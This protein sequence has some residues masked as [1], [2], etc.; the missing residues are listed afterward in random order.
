[1]A[2][3]VVSRLP[4]AQTSFENKYGP[5]G[6]VGPPGAMG[7]LPP[8]VYNALRDIDARRMM[9]GQSP[10]SETQT[11]LGAQA[12]ITGQAQTEEKEGN[13]LS[14]TISDANLILRS[15]P[16]LPAAMVDE[17][18]QLPEAGDYLARAQRQGG[19]PLGNLFMA[20]GFRLLPGAFVAGNV[21]GG[22]N[23][24][25][26]ETG[27]IG[28]LAEHPLFTGLDVLPYASGAAART[29][30]GRVA[31]LHAAETGARFRPIKTLATRK[32]DDAGE[33]VPNKFSERVLSP[34]GGRLKVTRPGQFLSEAFGE[35]GRGPARTQAKQTD[36]AHR[37]MSGQMDF[38]DD[39]GLFR[40]I[41]S[42]GKKL[43]DEGV[44]F[45]EFTTNIQRKSPTDFTDTELTRTMEY[46][47]LTDRL[48]KLG[49]DEG[50]LRRVIIGDSPEIYDIKTAKH[51]DRL[52]M[53]TRVAE[54]MVAAREAVFHPENL[55]ANTILD[56]LE[57]F[58]LDA[59]GRSINETRAILR[60]K[61]VALNNTQYDVSDLLS[62]VGNM[63]YGSI[64]FIQ[65]RLAQLF[66]NPAARIVGDTR[67]SVDELVRQ[68]TPMQRS[69]Q[70]VDRVITASKRGD[71][72]ETAKWIGELRDKGYMADIDPALVTRAH[73]E[74]RQWAANARFND[75]TRQFT[76]G[77][78]NR[79]KQREGEFIA[80]NPSARFHTVLEDE[81]QK[82]M[83][84]AVTGKTEG[85]SPK[86][87]EEAARLNREV[88]S[89]SPDT[90]AYL[91]Y[92]RNRSY[93]MVADLPP[94]EFVAL[95]NAVKKTWLQMREAGLDP[96]W[97]H[98]VDEGAARALRYPKILE[99]VLTPSQVKQRVFDSKPYVNDAQ[100]ALTH[101]AYEWLNRR[102]S[103]Q[104]IDDIAGMYG[105]DELSLRERFYPMAEKKAA[106]SGKGVE[107][108]LTHLMRREYAPFEPRQFVTWP[109]ARISPKAERMWVPKG[110]RR[111]IER[112]HVPPGERISGVLDPVMKVFRT[113]LL[114]LSPRWHVYNM[115]G[116]SVMLLARTD[117]TVLKYFG[118]AR[119]A[120]KEGTL[121]TELPLGSSLAPMAEWAFDW[122]DTITKA[123]RG[124]R[125]A[126]QQ[127]VGA[128][129][130]VKAGM[131][132][133]QWM[134]QLAPARDKFGNVVQKSY[135]WNMRVDDMGRAMA[136]LYNTDKALTKGLSK[137]AAQARGIALT[138]RIFQ[139][140]DEITPL[141][142][143]IMRFIFP[144]YS[145]TSHI[146]KYVMSYPADH[147][148][149]TSVMASFARNEIEDMGTGLPERF[150]SL[151]NIGSPDVNGKV[152]AINLSGLNPF[153]DTANWFSLAGFLA[154]EDG[155]LAAVTSNLN[156]IFS[157]VLSSVGVDPMKGNAEMYPN[158]RYNPDTG[159]IE[160]QAQNPVVSAINAIMPQS[161][162]LT[163]IATGNDEWKEL[164]RS[165]PDAASRMIQS[166]LFQFP[167]V[168]RTYNPT[169]ERIDAEVARIDDQSRARREALKSGNFDAMNA[170]PGLRA[171][172]EMV[173]RMDEQGILDQYR[174]ENAAEVVGV[175]R[176]ATGARD[177]L[178]RAL[179]M[180]LA[181]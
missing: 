1:M 173:K 95:K 169:E 102:G 174:P 58:P 39:P 100:V 171:Y 128:G 166:T 137:E 141:E 21:L 148:I 114:P 32:L 123:R 18:K 152:G 13:L 25:T 99:R 147:P 86:V 144:F 23:E 124:D 42:F 68:I 130:Q 70:M 120:L 90:D 43:A 14:N 69:N 181:G 140:W 16:R 154:G 118:Q 27:N 75:A 60:G 108:E 172:A 52:A 9:R 133:R 66:D 28:E 57:A 92:I 4:Q 101:Q 125:V 159:R 106:L 155:N 178:T 85:L 26:G 132:W 74:A 53:R 107:E 116:N 41:N 79:V 91:N 98:R 44:D 19:N 38:P 17:L 150:M 109:G 165:D 12:A 119:K 83:E 31:K 84:G 81:L 180:Q 158:L 46:R 97:V 5:G 126:K 10:L 63:T 104:F 64:P 61:L 78:L 145:W 117:P 162:L 22:Y 151:F 62:D 40:D 48:L 177:L 35:M 156:P 7:G 143:T 96:T 73:S 163:N 157:A 149:R 50:M 47:G 105:M 127:M 153:E 72:G 110:V 164:L 167:A 30:V 55:D 115:V 51:I 135:D 179:S 87:A 33:L 138:R 6:T 80:R 89:T 24:A 29:A 88:F 77:Y 121:P 168:Y 67:G 142:R 134:D 65:D 82:A 15:I 161:R 93:T 139:N 129:L 94:G 8:M 76:S 111:N 45:D 136:Y 37:V 146:L 170:Y 131:K 20:P 175:E 36:W 59:P 103:E 2:E 49:E 176:P 3:P 112:M 122:S 160:A 71:P 54:E 11:A 34:V 113:S 56:D